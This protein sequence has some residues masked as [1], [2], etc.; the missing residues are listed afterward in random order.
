MPGSVHD[1][2]AGDDFTV[3]EKPGLAARAGH[4]IAGEARWQPIHHPPE[5]HSLARAGGPQVGRIVAMHGEARAGRLAQGKRGTGVIDVVMGEDH[6]LEI[7]GVDSSLGEEAKDGPEAAGVAGIDDG[8]SLGALIEIG[9][10][11]SNSRDSFDH[12]P[13]SHS[14]ACTRGSGWGHFSSPSAIKF[15]P[16]LAQYLPPPLG[17][18]PGPPAHASRALVRCERLRR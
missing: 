4:H 12:N 9:M 14:P 7:L 3:L 8:K 16:P 15:P 10:R 18:G 17:E 6:P 1:R 2:E 5:G 11:A 13:Y